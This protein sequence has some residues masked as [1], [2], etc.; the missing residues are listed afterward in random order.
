[1]KVIQLLFILVLT[2]ASA[3]SYGGVFLEPLRGT[4]QLFRGRQP[5][6]AE[7]S[8]LPF[9]GITSVLIFK[10][11]TQN[12]VQEEINQLRQAGFDPL[13][14]YHIPMQWQDAP[15]EK[16]ACEQVISALQVLANVLQSPN[17]KILFHCTLGEDRTGLLTGLMT[18]LMNPVTTEEAYVSEMCQKGYSGGNKKKPNFI[19]QQVDKNLT[20][21]FFKL[22]MLIQ[23]R[24]LRLDNLN[25]NVCRDLALVQSNVILCRDIMAK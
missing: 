16:M 12:E 13:K 14:I 15:P 24:Q 17:E 5:T 3:N 19:Q 7:V 11:E 1:M 22:S 6:T 20:P 25:K 4:N 2:I 10:N 18:Q 8:Q 23:S 21:L 9:Q